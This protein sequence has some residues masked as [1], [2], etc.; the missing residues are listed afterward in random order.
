MADAHF[1][2]H[3]TLTSQHIARSDIP[4]LIT[5]ASVKVVLMIYTHEFISCCL[6]FAA[7]EYPVAL[8]TGYHY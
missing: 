1:D 7:D 3:F 4:A 2:G 6:M 5:Y 8:H